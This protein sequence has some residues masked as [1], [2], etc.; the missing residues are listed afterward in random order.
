MQQH[1]FKYLLILIFINK[2]VK[3]DLIHKPETYG[4]PIQNLLSSLDHKTNC[5]HLKNIDRPTC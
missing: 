4:L 5:T 3:G 2:L 1:N